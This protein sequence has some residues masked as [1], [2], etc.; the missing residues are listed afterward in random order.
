MRSPEYPRQFAARPR[1]STNRLFS[2]ENAIEPGDVPDPVGDAAIQSLAGV[3]VG[4]L[5]LAVRPEREVLILHEADEPGVVFVR[6]RVERLGQ[7]V[8]SEV[9]LEFV[10]VWRVAVRGVERLG[11]EEKVVWSLIRF[12]RSL[13][14]SLSRT[15]RRVFTCRR[16]S[17]SMIC[18]TSPPK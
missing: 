14:S 7:G 8:L 17:P 3:K 12:Q 9:V 16:S 18:A 2:G 5:E 6:A 13:N 1:A 4:L 10:G 11:Q 15:A